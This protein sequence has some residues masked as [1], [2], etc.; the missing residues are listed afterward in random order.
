M[1]NFTNFH[2]RRGFIIVEQYIIKGFVMTLKPFLLKEANRK[3]FQKVFLLYD[4]LRASSFFNSSLLIWNYNQTQYKRTSEIFTDCPKWVCCYISTSF[5]NFWTEFCKIG[6]CVKL[7]YCRFNLWQNGNGDVV[8]NVAM[9]LSF[10]SFFSS[11]LDEINFGSFF[12]QGAP[13]WDLLT[14]GTLMLLGAEN[15]AH[16]AARQQDPHKLGF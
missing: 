16:P 11:W 15:P 1:I 10:P 14:D 2:M 12:V 3:Y 9:S 5:P 6:H 13:A 8:R 7:R 4:H